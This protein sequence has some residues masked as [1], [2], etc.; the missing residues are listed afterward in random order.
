M[1]AFKSQTFL[2]GVPLQLSKR[3]QYTLPP[4]IYR[5]QFLPLTNVVGSN[6]PK[7]LI[8]FLALFRLTFHSAKK[9]FNLGLIF[10]VGF[11][12]CVI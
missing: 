6:F 8:K 10:A 11:Y 4:L 5:K 7:V 1:P 3:N 12:V 9:L 2:L